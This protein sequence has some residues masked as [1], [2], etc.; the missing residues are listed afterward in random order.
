MQVFHRDSRRRSGGG[1][2]LAGWLALAL[3]GA[4]SHGGSDGRGGKTDLAV[5]QAGE[6][7]RRP[8]DPDGSHDLRAPGDAAT[9]GDSGTASDL[10]QSPDLSTP[11]DM[12]TMGPPCKRGVGWTAFRFKFDGSTFARLDGFGLPDSSNWEASIVRSTSFTDALH[13]GGAELGSGNFILVR[14]SLVGLTTI[15]GATLSMYGRSYSTGSSGSFRA[16]SPLYGDIAPPDNSVS[17][18]WP[19]SWTSVDY[20]ANVRVGDDKSLTAFRFYPG[21]NSNDLVV[22]TVELCLDAS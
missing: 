8:S 16:W 18:A 12:R 6:D 5:G 4:C 20:T 7:L 22:N 14:F 13:G 1:G 19:Y 2:L 15:R 3:G 17:N 9:A 21:P 11:V 10:A